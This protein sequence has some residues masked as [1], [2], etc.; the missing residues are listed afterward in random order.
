MQHTHEQ[1]A[2]GQRVEDTVTGIRG[3]VTSLSDHISDCRTATVE[4]QDDDGTLNRTTRSVE[5][6][7]VINDGVSS[8]V[9]GDGRAIMKH[10]DIELGDTVV[11]EPSGFE[12]VVTL[13]T[14]HAFEAT[15]LYVRPQEVGPDGRKSGEKLHA[16]EVNLVESDTMD[17]DDVTDDAEKP[18]SV[19]G[20]GERLLDT[21]E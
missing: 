7:R 14:Y 8:Q 21:L 3:T 1:V 6:F 13:V 5:R 16:F 10:K 17:P 19:D 2:L 20:A 4:Y 9:N 18:G 12:G 11:H 15:K